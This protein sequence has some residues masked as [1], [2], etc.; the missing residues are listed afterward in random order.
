MQTI[1]KRVFDF[2]PLVF[3]LGFLVPLIAQTLERTGWQAP[4]G[5]SPLVFGLILGGTLGLIAQIRGRW[6]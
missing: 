3:G 4:L 2:G 1:I 5:L 6:I